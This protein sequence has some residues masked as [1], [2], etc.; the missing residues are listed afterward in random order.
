MAEIT[1]KT[2]SFNLRRKPRLGETIIQG[3]LFFSGFFS[4]FTTVGIVY[5]LGKEA[6]LFFQMPEVNML[7][8]LTTTEWKPHVGKFGIWPLLTSTMMTTIIAMAIAI[9]CSVTVSMADDRIGRLSSMSLVTRLRMSTSVGSTSERAG[10]SST[11]SK[12]SA[13]S[14][15]MDEMIFAK[16][17]PF[18]PLMGIR[19]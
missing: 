8:T 10:C 11:S 6:F 1:E 7:A 19:N 3:L 15:V 2:S 5:E 9:P 18:L 14:P 17:R 16:A 12:V 4:I 13:A